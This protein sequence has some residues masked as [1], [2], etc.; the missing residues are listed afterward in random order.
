MQLTGQA[1]LPS[2]GR[3]I[4]RISIHPD[5]LKANS[6]LAGDLLKLTTSAQP[7]PCIFLQAWPSLETEVGIAQLSLYHI[8][9]LQPSLPHFVNSQLPSCSLD[10]RKVKIAKA[11][12]R[13][14]KSIELVELKVENVDVIDKDDDDGQEQDS[15]ERESGW[16]QVCAKESIVNLKHITPQTVIYIPL[17]NSTSPPRAFRIKSVNKQIIQTTSSESIEDAIADKVYSLNLG[18]ED[19]AKSFWV[20]SWGTE[21]T[22]DLEAKEKD[23]EKSKGKIVSAAKNRQTTKSQE[24]KEGTSEASYMRVHPPASN[25]TAG[26]ST[27]GGLSS[28]I[29]K[30]REMIELPLLHPTLYTHLSLPPPRGILLYGPPGTGKT[31]LCRAIANSTPDCS[32]IIINGSE[33]SSS[34]HG[35]TEE[36]LRDVW[37][38]AKAHSPC[39][40]VLDEVDALAPRRDE[41]GG[42]VERRVVATLLT[43]MDG[44]GKDDDSARVVV[45]GATNRPNALDPALRRPGRFDREIEIGVPDAAARL[46]ILQVLLS[47]R[48]NDITSD[49]L[50]EIAS[51][52]HGY[53]G[54]DLTSLI[55]EAGNFAISSYLSSSLATSTSTGIDDSIPTGLKISFGDMIHALS[56]VRPSAM[57]EVFLETP[58]VKWSDIG[59]Q[60]E[61]KQKLK[62]CV[63]WPLLYKSTFDRLG[64]RPPRGV[65]LYGPPGCSKTLTAKALATESGINF[66]AVKGPELLNKYVGESERAVREVF[67]KARVASPSIIFFDEID[68]LGTSRSDD[69][70]STHTSG[71]LTSILNE[72]DGIEE[73]VGVTVVA[74]TNRPDVID[75]ALMRPGRIDRILYVGPPSFEA[76]IEIFNITLRK[77]PVESGLDVNELAKMTDGC[78]GAE[79]VQICQDAALRA[80]QEN[81]EAPYT[82]V[83]DFHVVIKACRKS[84]TPEMVEFFEEWRDGQIVQSA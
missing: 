31:A 48:P 54:A 42:E 75:S 17:P 22:V 57:R 49:S 52:T 77:M 67:R 39:V 46:S 58:S 25:P 70:S 5:D 9:N 20:T 16:V 14:A 65:L 8:F 30:V 33:L 34:Y 3:S 4:R 43:L 37:D 74:A 50:A 51:K 2:V 12:M 19:E 56:Q 59:G 55:R 79:I 71:V 1:E 32:C 80:M 13:E 66:L 63:E 7:S 82:R 61:V 45:V 47:V 40:V 78:S 72:M 28:Q 35:E 64:V 36:R 68:A 6:L 69:A 29:Q 53:V 41:G 18:E 24:S 81:I 11:A 26:Y 10:I 73:L 38:R 44:M 84:I 21:V 27:L 62:E 76:R 60:D 23:I 15:R 83:E